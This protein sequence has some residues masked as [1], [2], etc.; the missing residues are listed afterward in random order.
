MYLAL[1]VYK[2]DVYPCKNKSDDD[3][4]DDINCLTPW[5]KLDKIVELKIITAKFKNHSEFSQQFCPKLE[6]KK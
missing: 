3:G 2:P 5:F 6:N 4:D 1:F